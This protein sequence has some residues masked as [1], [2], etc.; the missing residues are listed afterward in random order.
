MTPDFSGVRTAP[1]SVRDRHPLVWAAGP[2]LLAFGSAQSALAAVAAASRRRPPLLGGDAVL[3]QLTGHTVAKPSAP[4]VIHLPVSCPGRVCVPG[5]Q[6]I[7]PGK[8][9]SGGGG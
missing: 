8:H 1:Y 2:G 5:P 6:G 9:V 4:A 3:L 7:V